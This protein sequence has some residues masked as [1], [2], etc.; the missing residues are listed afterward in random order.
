MPTYPPPKLLI[1][2]P[3]YCNS[4]YKPDLSTTQNHIAAHKQWYPC[5][6]ISN[7]FKKGCELPPEASNRLQGPD[8]PLILS[9]ALS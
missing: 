7:S 1:S 9:H 8:S 2:D 4:L 6:N 5:A 3:D